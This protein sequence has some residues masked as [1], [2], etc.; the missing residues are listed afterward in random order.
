MPKRGT[1]EHILLLHVLSAETFVLFLWA[2]SSSLLM[3]LDFWLHSSCLPLFWWTWPS[4]PSAHLDTEITPQ[5]TTFG[6]LPSPWPLL[7]K[8]LFN[9]VPVA[10]RLTICQLHPTICPWSHPVHDCRVSRAEAEEG[11]PPPWERRPPSPNLMKM[12]VLEEPRCRVRR[13]RAWKLEGTGYRFSILPVLEPFWDS[14]SKD[15]WSWADT[16]LPHIS[17]PRSR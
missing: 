7:G 1:W 10:W 8:Y 9:I 4:I 15:P 12:G 2:Y 6:S 16:N 11:S 14:F 13:T 17:K 3:L 5:L